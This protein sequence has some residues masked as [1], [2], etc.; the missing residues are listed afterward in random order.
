VLK[1]IASVGGHKHLYLQNASQFDSDVACT[2]D[3]D[4]WRQVLE[5]KKTVA[6]DSKF[7]TLR[8]EANFNQRQ[9]KNSSECDSTGNCRY[10]WSTS[11]GY[12]DIFALKQL[13]LHLDRL[14]VDKF[15]PPADAFDLLCLKV[16]LVPFVESF[17]VVVTFRF[18]LGPLKRFFSHSDRENE[19][20]QEKKSIAFVLR[21]GVTS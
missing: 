9:A 1:R 11:G 13:I 19:K 3:G 14:G 8:D 6:G 17:Y 10:R 5:L 15:A 2:D 21:F 7:G 20:E 12:E 4:S 16:I 18:A